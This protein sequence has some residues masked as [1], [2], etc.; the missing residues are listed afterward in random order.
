MFVC[1]DCKY[2]LNL[3]QKGRDWHWPNS[4]GECEM[5]EEFDDCQDD[6][7]GYFTKRD[8][9]DTRSSA[10]AAEQA[11]MPGPTVMRAAVE[12]NGSPT[13][14]RFAYPGFNDDGEGEAAPESLPPPLS[15]MVSAP[16]GAASAAEDPDADAESS[17]MPPATVASSQPSE[18]RATNGRT[19]MRSTTRPNRPQP[20]SAAATASG[21][22]QPQV[23]P[24]A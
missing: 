10:A 5:C 20:A 2:D 13:Q 11:H 16:L 15:A 17:T 18:P 8:P 19:R 9:E 1:E 24:R 22:G 3:T 4:L 12:A 14:Y 23:T 7:D 21:I 6:I